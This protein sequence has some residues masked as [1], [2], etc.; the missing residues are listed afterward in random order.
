MFRRLIRSLSL[1]FF[2]FGFLGWA[3]I[4]ANSLVH[5]ETLDQPLSHLAL[6]IRED[7]FGLICFIVSFISFFVWNIT[8]A[9]DYNRPIRSLALAVFVFSLL[10]WL[11]ITTIAVTGLATLEGPLT[12]LTL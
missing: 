2:V 9:Q 4:A 11:Y 5:P 8:K 3:Y 10:G 6:W 7:T 12:H 1:T